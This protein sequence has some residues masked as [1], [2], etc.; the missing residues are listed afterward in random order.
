MNE[1][2]VNEP[3]QCRLVPTSFS[4]AGGTTDFLLYFGSNSFREGSFLP[5]PP[6]LLFSLTPPLASP[7]CLFVDRMCESV[8]EL[9]EQCQ[10]Q[11]H[12]DTQDVSVEREN[13]DFSKKG[14]D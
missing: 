3:P 13:N 4:I 5:P 1:T 8:A 9:L 12:M 10:G 7:P 2:Q 11:Q 14:P 6:H